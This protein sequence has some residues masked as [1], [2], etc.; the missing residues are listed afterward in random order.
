MAVKD[1]TSEFFAAVDSAQARAG[2]AN[3][4]PEKSRLLNG[5][6]SDPRTNAVNSPTQVPQNKSEFTKGASSIAREINGT[7]VKLQK[8]MQLAKR[9]TLFDDRPVEINELI[10]IIKQDI[11]K[12]NK[13]IVSL[14]TYVQ[15][16]RN[17][18][19]GGSSY[20]GK[21]FGGN[22]QV[23]EHSAHV[24]TNLQSRLASTS[25]VFKNILEIRTQNMKEQKSRRDQYSYVPAGGTS[26]PMRSG[27]SSSSNSPGLAGLGPSM[28]A[29]Q[30][31][32]PLYNPIP[33]QDGRHSSDVVIDFGTGGGQQLVQA[34]SSANLEYIESRAQ[35]IESIEST[36]AE[37]GQ[38]YQH[39]TQ[40]VMAQREMVQR[41]DDNI[42]DV[43]VNVSRAHGELTKFYQGMI[44][45]RWFMVK[46]MAVVLFFFLLYVLVS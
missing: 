11:A 42:M 10:Y 39:F 21:Y 7:V 16:Q 8:L 32:S 40:I 3:G 14:Q 25:S 26:T 1:R 44:S 19:G 41:I 38:I 12:I 33:N 30:S 13:H 36:I 45:N 24:I 20:G 2:S 29:P 22:R 35:A 17:A 43:E 4:A 28:L 9:K 46:V 27:G 6:S 18:A 34:T 15:Q 5:S 23:D 37:L 31:D